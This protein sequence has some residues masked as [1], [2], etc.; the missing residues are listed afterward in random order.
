MKNKTKINKKVD[1]FNN[2]VSIKTGHYEKDKL[3]QIL[4]L[5]FQLLPFQF[6]QESKVYNVK[7]LGFIKSS[8]LVHHFKK[9]VFPY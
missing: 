6:L 9:Q 8:L 7:T 1:I 4:F 5:N 2:T 3:S